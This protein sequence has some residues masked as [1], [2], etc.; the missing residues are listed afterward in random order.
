MLPTIAKYCQ[1]LVVQTRLNTKVVFQKH[2]EKTYRN[3]IQFR[4]ACHGGPNG[5]NGLSA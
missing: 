4:G 1:Q 2:F 5:E 3:D